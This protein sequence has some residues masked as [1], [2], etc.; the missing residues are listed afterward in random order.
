MRLNDSNALERVRVPAWAWLAVALAAA[1]AYL[2]TMEN[3]IVL[4]Q[5]ASAL[6]E[7]FHDAR[8]FVG[9]PCH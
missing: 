1:A 8:H 7:L 5:R 4:A 2:L 9:V 3:G 6:H